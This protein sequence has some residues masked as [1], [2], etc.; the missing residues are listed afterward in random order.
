MWAQSL[1]P[2]SGSASHKV[3]GKQNSLVGVERYQ[4]PPDSTN[5]CL[6]EARTLRGGSGEG[7]PP[8]PF[9]EPGATQ[10]PFPVPR[11]LSPPHLP[12][13]LPCVYYDPVCT[14]EH[15]FCSRPQE[16]LGCW[17]PKGWFPE[18]NC[19]LQAPPGTLRKLLVLLAAPAGCLLGHQ[20]RERQEPPSP[21]QLRSHPSL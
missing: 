2:V 18:C 8:I 14:W 7:S 15:T 21:Q 6:P 1:L 19:P 5:S 4:I 3:T 11:T 12:H 10:V 16:L 17:S 20:P 13:A 9:P